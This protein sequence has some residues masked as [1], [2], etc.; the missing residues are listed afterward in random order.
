MNIHL[1][2]IGGKLKTSASFGTQMN[3]EPTIT[4]KGTL[5][6]L[7]SAKMKKSVQLLNLQ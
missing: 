3:L 7:F 5:A 1:D 4:Q 6:G 2:N